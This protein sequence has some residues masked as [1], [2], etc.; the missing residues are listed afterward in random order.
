MNNN[1]Q[2]GSL[3]SGTG[4]GIGTVGSIQYAF[5]TGTATSWQ[6]LW[7]PPPTNVGN[8]VI[9]VTVARGG[10]TFANSYTL[11]PAGTTPPTLTLSVSPSTLTFTAS[12]TAPPPQTVHPTS[13]GAPMAYTTSAATIPPGG[14]WLHATPGGANTPTDVTVSVDPTGL[15]TGTYMGTVS[16]ASSSATNSPQNVGVTFNWTAPT[17][18]PPTPNLRSLPTELRFDAASAGDTAA[19]QLLNV[20]SSDAS[21][22]V[23]TDAASTDSGGNW[24][25]VTPGSGSTP[26]SLSVSVATTGLA[27]G[28]FTGAI[29]IASS[30]ATNSPLM[31]PV[32]LRIGETPPPTV[33]LQFSLTVVDKQSGGSDEMLLIG[34]G[35]S[36]GSGAVTG[37]GQFTRYTPSSNTGPDQIVSTGTWRATSVVSFT[38]VSSTDTS[39]GVLVINVNLNP[40]GGSTVP[41][42]MRI[43][44]TGS[45]SGVT[46][47]ITGGDTFAPTGVGQVSIAARGGTGGDG[48][49]DGGDS[50]GG[51]D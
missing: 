48:S 43:A 6:L 21:T 41:A 37:G 7:T 45:D 11:T 29:A 26:A 28:T 46:L 20:T 27:N 23:F 36:D 35:S 30:G 40:A 47:T 24:L 50:G 18:P 8:V 10:N 17:T 19:A 2:A 3:A 39:H 9:Y 5:Q 4:S 34:T 38:P 33:A 12:G 22:L 44:N 31:V 13:S 14:A 1:S 15:S 32:T 42:T 16:V 51:N 25:T 49:G